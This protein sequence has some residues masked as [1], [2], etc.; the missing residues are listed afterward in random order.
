MAERQPRDF[1]TTT[2]SPHEQ[3]GR[4]NAATHPSG[5]TRT[6][7]A[8]QIFGVIA[9]VVTTLVAAD[10]RAARLTWALVLGSS[11][12][13]LNLALR[14]AAHHPWNRRNLV[15]IAIQT[16]AVAALIGIAI[17]LSPTS[18][19]TTARNT[20]RGPAATL[21]LAREN[22]ALTRSSFID[23]NDQDK[24]DLDTACP[25]WGNQHP[26]LGPSRCGE[27]AD[28]ILDEEGIHNANSRPNIIAP[29]PDS[30]LDVSS[31]NATFS[32][33]PAR[34]VSRVSTRDL[35]VGSTFCVKTDLDATVL[36]EIDTIDTDPDGALQTLTI[37]FKVWKP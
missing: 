36:V 1:P 21:D 16:S 13:G 35:A 32:A 23:T 11:I 34:L 6:A 28:L 7:E 2:K 9:A 20:G 10:T 30:P 25:G 33:D 19:V 8:A 27:L 3:A 17:N 22:Y 31:C 4:T 15:V 29:N 5:L 14:L 24:V 26:R 12:V 18:S 37:S